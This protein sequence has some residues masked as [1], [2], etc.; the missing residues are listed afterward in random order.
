MTVAFP[1]RAGGEPPCVTLDDEAEIGQRPALRLSRTEAA[2][3]GAPGIRCIADAELRDGLGAQ[4]ALLHILER[5]RVARQRFRVELRHAGHEVVESLGIARRRGRAA[6]LTRYLESEPARELFDSLGKG[7]AVVLHQEAQ[8]G[9]VRAAAE[10]VIEL[11][12]R[13]HPEGGGLL[14]MERAAGLVLAARFLQ[15][16]A[17]AD[18]LHDVR[19]G[20]QLVDEALGDDGWISLGSRPVFP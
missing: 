8:H 12:L 19:A 13:A 9:S 2:Q 7:H 20:D 5:A 11:L 18:H 6:R 16:H 1:S 17:R 4:A 14:V 15:L 3:H 10:A